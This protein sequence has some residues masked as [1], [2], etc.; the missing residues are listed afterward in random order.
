[1]FECL[2]CFAGLEEGRSFFL[3]EDYSAALNEFLPLAEQGD[4]DAQLQLAWLYYTSP[5]SLKV[6]NYAAEALKWY[7]RAAEQGN[8][9][10]QFFVGRIYHAGGVLGKYSDNC[11]IDT[12]IYPERVLPEE[13]NKKQNDRCR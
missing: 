8:A 4:V 9:K 1:M 5:D 12:V 10:A 6:K 13:Y 2:K 11:D 7:G 3:K